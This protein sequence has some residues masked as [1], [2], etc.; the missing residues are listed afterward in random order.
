MKILT[1]DGYGNEGG[2]GEKP[3]IEWQEGKSRVGGLTR[4]EGES[5][6]TGY[7]EYMWDRY[8]TGERE[9]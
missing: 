8:L 3:L 4:V 7:R 6:L 2:F 5:R 1:E 9:N